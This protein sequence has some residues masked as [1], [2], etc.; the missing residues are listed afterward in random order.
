MFLTNV[1][2]KERYCFSIHLYEILVIW[3]LDEREVHKVVSCIHLQERSQMVVSDL[4]LQEM[5]IMLPQT[6]FRI[7]N[8]AVVSEIL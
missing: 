8:N 7:R 1:Y 3:W 5:Y 6:S 2:K 4:R